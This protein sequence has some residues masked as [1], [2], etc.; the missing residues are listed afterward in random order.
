MQDTDT[1][2]LRAPIPVM[3][4]FDVPKARAFYVDYL[5]FAWDWEH[6]FEADLPLYAQVSRGPCR[7]HLSEHHGDGSPGIVCFVPVADIDAL[8]AELATRDYPYLR[9]GIENVGWGRQMQLT[10]P[11]GNR[12]R[13]CELS[14]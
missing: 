7:L 12:L 4:I 2:G 5:G 1:T 3:R 6:R 10:D 8:H 11:F 9:P 14:D 13:F